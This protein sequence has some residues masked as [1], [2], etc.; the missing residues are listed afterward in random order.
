MRNMAEKMRRDK[1]NNYINELAGIVPL[2]SGG[3]KRLDKTSTLRLAANYIRMHKIL[4]KEDDEAEKV[5]PVLGGNIAHNLAEAVGGFLLVVTS[6]G[7]VVYVTEAVDQ[8]FGHSQVD[9]LGHSIYNVIHPDDHEIFQQQLIP[10]GNNRVSFFCRM[11]E[12]ALTRNDP[13]RY[14]IIHIVGQLKPIPASANVVP[15]SPATSVLS[16]DGRSNSDTENY[17]SDGDVDNQTMKAAINRIGTHILVSFVRVVKDRPITELSLVE[18]T[19]DEYITR[20]GLGGSIMYTDHRISFVTGLMPGEVVGTS[21]FSYMHPEDRVWSIVAQKLMFT[22]TEGQGIVSYRLQCRD[23]SF[24]T[25]RS[26]GYLEVNKQT[27]QVESF[28]CINT[29]VSLKE[30]EDEIKNQR[31]KL[32]PVI[33]SSD[34]EDHLKNI[35]S[36]LPPELIKDVLPLLTPEA[37]QQMAATFEMSELKSDKIVELSDISPEQSHEAPVEVM[38][39][40]AVENEDNPYQSKPKKVCNIEKSETSS[41]EFTKNIPGANETTSKSPDSNLWYNDS[42]KLTSLD[43]FKTDVTK[44]FSFE[45][46]QFKQDQAQ[47][48]KLSPAASL[49]VQICP[50]SPQYGSKTCYQSSV[51]QCDGLTDQKLTKGISNYLPNKDT[52]SP[53]GDHSPLGKESEFSPRV[54]NY[55]I[56]GSVSLAGNQKNEDCS[57]KP[58]EQMNVNVG[59]SK[60]E[61]SPVSVKESIDNRISY[62]QGE[63]QNKPGGMSSPGCTFVRNERTVSPSSAYPLHSISDGLLTDNPQDS[64][65][66]LVSYASQQEWGNGSSVSDVAL[67]PKCM[68]T[69]APH[70]QHNFH[71]LDFD[72]SVN[73]M[74]QS[75][76]TCQRNS[77]P[78]FSPGS[79]LET[80]DDY[81]Q[82]HQQL[83]HQRYNQQQ[84]QQQQQLKQHQQLQLQQQCQQQQ[85]QQQLQQQQQQQQ[86]HFHYQPAMSTANVRHNFNF[87]STPKF[88]V[89]VQGHPNKS[90]PQNYGSVTNWQSRTDVIPCH[91]SNTS[92]ENPDVFTSTNL[93]PHMESEGGHASQCD[94]SL[95]PNTGSPCSNNKSVPA[96]PEVCYSYCVP[97]QSTVESHLGTT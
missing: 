66:S 44:S 24:V 16:P 49:Q 33:S 40:R 1:L 41:V 31:R 74:N 37:L 73:P 42:D 85:Q 39:N 56:D 4:A 64:G 28:V 76:T 90:L 86:Q 67:S 94:A 84:L 69:A 88:D 12:K 52:H 22:S 3:S 78:Q 89:K 77:H 34:C 87:S 61:Y 83:Q 30:S 17:E 36:T 91:P 35:S 68:N 7:R 50:A 62:R 54:G 26:R 75:G 45:R 70:G 80:K 13:G 60:P 23:G 25:L 14:E 92:G 48:S 32:L 53:A 79:M 71:Q 5:P 19:Q 9:L 72:T 97:P 27:G 18:S 63:P 38:K 47:S 65:I 11:M 6:T 82:V 10:R 15:C 20:H 93:L 51:N 96:Q 43:D 95:H 55:S 2:G 59:I 46:E 21:A 29:V 58:P 8:F 81:H 57:S